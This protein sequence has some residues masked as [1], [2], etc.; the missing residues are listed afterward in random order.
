MAFLPFTML[1]AH[2]PLS[3][4]T[5]APRSRSMAILAIFGWHRRLA[6]P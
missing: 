4:G 1:T 3:S 6:R 5:L 2:A